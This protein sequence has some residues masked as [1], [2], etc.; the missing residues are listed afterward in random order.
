[1][2]QK[3]ASPCFCDFRSLIKE[4]ELGNLLLELQPHLILLVY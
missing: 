1:M 3:I 4:N 2:V